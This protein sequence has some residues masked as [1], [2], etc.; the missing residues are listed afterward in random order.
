MIWPKFWRQEL[1][2]GQ[3]IGI[4]IAERECIKLVLIPSQGPADG[5]W[6]NLKALGPI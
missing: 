3:A 5:S 4:I 6:F 2:V 1:F